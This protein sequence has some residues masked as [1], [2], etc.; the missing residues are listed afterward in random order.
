MWGL[1]GIA[2]ASGISTSIVDR[3]SFVFAHP[4]WRGVGVILFGVGALLTDWGIRTLTSR[5]SQGLGGDLHT[6]GPYRFSRNPQY[7]GDMLMA[8]GVVVGFDSRLAAIAAVGGIACLLYAPLAE[9]PW[10]EAHYGNAY[11]DYARHTPRYV[12]LRQQRG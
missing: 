7:V 2:F 6:S 12:R 8:I 10:L 3:G 1:T 9:E 11:R 4:I 5:T